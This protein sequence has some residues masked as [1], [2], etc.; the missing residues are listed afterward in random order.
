MD[1]YWSAVYEIFDLPV[2][3]GKRDAL[4]A[5][6]DEDRQEIDW[7]TITD[8][9]RPWSH[10]ERVLVRIAHVLYNEG[11]RVGIDEISVF[12]SDVRRS[13]FNIIDRFY[14]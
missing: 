8:I 6:V 10:G 12:S 7:P 4:Y 11:E 14:G 13:V 3:A 5:Y 1:R 2:L 9:I